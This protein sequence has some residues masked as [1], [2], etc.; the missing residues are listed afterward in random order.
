MS[1]T[2]YQRVEDMEEAKAI[3]AFF[4]WQRIPSKIEISPKKI[5]LLTAGRGFVGVVED[6]T[7]KFIGNYFNTVKYI[8]DKGMLLC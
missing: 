4:D 7:G 6:E 5:L 1:F 2:I 8:T 3:K